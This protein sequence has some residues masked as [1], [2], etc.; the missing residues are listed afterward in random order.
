MLVQRVKKGSVTSGQLKESIGPGLVCLVAVAGDDCEEDV[1][2]TSSK[3]AVLRIFSDYEGKFNFSVKDTGGEVLA[4]PQF[5]LYGDCSKGRRPGFEKS[6]GKEKALKYFN[7]Y[8]EFLRQEGVSVKKGFFGREME[9]EIINDG[10]VSLIIE[11]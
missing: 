11:S 1:R 6:A 3:T 7:L 9:V 10:P 2:F 5:T 4:V 8:I